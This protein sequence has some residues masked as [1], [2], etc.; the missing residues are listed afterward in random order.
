MGSLLQHAALHA[1]T[2]VCADDARPAWQTCRNECWYLT[3]AA[4]A[5]HTHTSF[6][7]DR[8]KVTAVTSMRAGRALLCLALCLAALQTSLAVSASITTI[9]QLGVPLTHLVADRR[10]LDVAYGTNTQGN[11]LYK[12]QLAS[13]RCE[14]RPTGETCSCGGYVGSRG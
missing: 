8:F 2:A 12:V 11:M 7:P 4:T 5:G 14:W 13:G 6:V 10:S 3:P 9:C 1:T